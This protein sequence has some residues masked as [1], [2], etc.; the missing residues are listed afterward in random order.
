MLTLK[1]E[2]SIRQARDNPVTLRIHTNIFILCTLLRL[3]TVL[4]PQ[5]ETVIGEVR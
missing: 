2:Q 4:T 5:I 3:H 1:R